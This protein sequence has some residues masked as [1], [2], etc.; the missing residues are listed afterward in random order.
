MQK[1]TIL[2]IA[3]AM[4]ANAQRIHT[5]PSA[6]NRVIRL[7]TTPNHLSVIELAEPVTE[8]AAGSSSYKIEWRDNKVFRAAS[9][10]GSCHQP[11]HL[12]RNPAADLRTRDGSIRR[13]RAVL[14]SIQ[15][16]P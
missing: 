7:Q 4:V 6:R 8:V 15:F 11:L 16:L 1:T 9:R 13:G 10:T 5:E 14:L 2:A 3:V 12:D